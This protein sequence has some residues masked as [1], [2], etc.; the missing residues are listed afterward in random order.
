MGFSQESISSNTDIKFKIQDSIFD[1]QVF[2]NELNFILAKVDSISNENND[3]AFY[4]FN[5]A[6]IQLYLDPRRNQSI[7]PIY[8]KFTFQDSLIKLNITK[9]NNQTREIEINKFLE[10]YKLKNGFQKPKK[11]IF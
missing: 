11:W 3:D 5:R 6:T 1:E 10:I 7:F 9:N 8:Y 4:D 2:E